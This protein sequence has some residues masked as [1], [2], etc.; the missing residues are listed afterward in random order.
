MEQITTI[1]KKK[2]NIHETNHDYWGT[3]SNLKCGTI[4]YGKQKYKY[5]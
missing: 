1:K 2:I 5:Y 3:K 4:K